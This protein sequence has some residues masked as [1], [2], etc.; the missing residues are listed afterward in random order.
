MMV[1]KIE[2]RELP[3]VAAV[4]SRAFRDN[5]GLGGILRG[6]SADKRERVLL[7][8]MLGFARA[9]LRHGTIEAVRHDGNVVAASLVLP[10]GAFPLPMR[11]QLSTAAGVLRSRPARVLRFA[12][13]AHELRKV[14]P[15]GPHYYLWFLGVEPEQWGRGLGSSLLRSLTARADAEQL[16]CYLE[17]DRERAVGLYQGHGFRVCGEGLVPGMNARMWFM[18]RPTER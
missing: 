14:H 4:L 8:C 1:E 7:G 15:P 17:T 13:A 5:P 11:G 18:Q 10:P 12:R 6:D 16:P 3:A 9:V 2:A